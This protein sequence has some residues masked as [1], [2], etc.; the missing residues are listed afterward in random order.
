MTIDDKLPVIAWN[1]GMSLIPVR[2]VFIP[3]V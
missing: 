3:E 2:S 1:V